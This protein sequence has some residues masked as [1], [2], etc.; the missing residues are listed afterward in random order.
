MPIVEGWTFVGCYS[1]GTP[2]SLQHLGGS[3]GHRTVS[4]CLEVCAA[5]Q[6]KL[7]G[8]EYGS[9][10]CEFL[11]TTAVPLTFLTTGKP[12]WQRLRQYNPPQPRCTP[13]K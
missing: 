3:S 1:D 11:I 9:E 10:C 5:G 2:R 6:F 12:T 7:G 13:P 8:V 4:K